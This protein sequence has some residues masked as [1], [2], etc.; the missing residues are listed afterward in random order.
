[1]LDGAD[2]QFKCRL[3]RPSI[4]SGFDLQ[5]DVASVSFRAAF[6]SSHK[7]LIASIAGPRSRASIRPVSN[8]G[9]SYPIENVSMLTDPLDSALNGVQ[10]SIGAVFRINLGLGSHKS[11]RLLV[12]HSE[13]PSLVTFP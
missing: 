8:D 6:A 10:Y 1:V 11:R 4:E 7:L 9:P 12:F 2:H 13:P 5:G 3:E